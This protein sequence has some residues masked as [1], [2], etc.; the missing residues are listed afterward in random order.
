M[1]QGLRE[2]PGSAGT[3]R[4]APPVHQTAR[5][6]QGLLVATGHHSILWLQAK[7]QRES[8]LLPGG[9]APA[10]RPLKHGNIFQI[11][12]RLVASLPWP[13]ALGGSWY[14]GW[15]W[16]WGHGASRQ[17]HNRHIGKTIFLEKDVGKGDRGGRG[18]DS[19]TNFL[20][21]GPSLHSTPGAQ[22]TDSHRNMSQ[23]T[24]LSAMTE[25][26]RS[27][28]PNLNNVTNNREFPKGGSWSDLTEGQGRP[29]A[30]SLGN[31]RE[32]AT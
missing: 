29:P 10:G 13:T 18:Q 20:H 26:E 22:R 9:R 21:P 25:L 24:Q 15:P 14:W 1:L 30:P 31:S 7:P 4:A 23:V 32:G 17:R 11:P 19:S 8:V 2:H 16:R 27:K 28:T 3:G 5:S 6:R 12:S